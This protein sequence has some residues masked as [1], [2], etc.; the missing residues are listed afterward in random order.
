MEKEQVTD[1]QMATQ[2]G[3]IIDSL[4]EAGKK[5]VGQFFNLMVERT[6]DTA[7][8]LADK[9]VEKIKKKIDE[10]GSHDKED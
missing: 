9:G 5:A 1:K 3:G 4:A 8:N 7:S 10:T 6:A 2:V